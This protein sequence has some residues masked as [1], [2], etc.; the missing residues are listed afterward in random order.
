MNVFRKIGNAIARFMY[1]RNGMDQLNL[2]LMIL[3]LGMD[4]PP[5]RLFLLLIIYRIGQGYNI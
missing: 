5:V 4:V 2:A 1:G 3:V